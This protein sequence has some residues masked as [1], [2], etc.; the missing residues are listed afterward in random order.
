MRI[1]RMNPNHHHPHQMKSQQL[2]LKIQVSCVC[3]LMCFS[4]L[5]RNHDVQTSALFTK[6][7]FLDR[8]V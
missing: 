2:E 5:S 4:A 6:N 7:D 8:Q 3:V 1:Q